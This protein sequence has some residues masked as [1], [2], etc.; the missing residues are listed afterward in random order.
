MGEIG[1]NVDNAASHIHAGKA[2]KAF[3]VDR[4]IGAYDE[5]ARVGMTPLHRGQHL[6]GEPYHGIDVRPVVHRPCEHHDV[7]LTVVG[8]LVRAVGRKEV[9]IDAITHREGLGGG[10]RSALA[11]QFGLGGR[12]EEVGV[13]RCSGAA[14]EG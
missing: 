2:G 3:Y 1:P 4:G 9:D 10:L 6:A 11:E 5:E 7:G 14:F 12:H 13:E 8:I